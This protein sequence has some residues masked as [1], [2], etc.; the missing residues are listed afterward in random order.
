MKKIS[1]VAILF[2]FA[3]FGFAQDSIR[4]DS[5][6][7]IQTKGQH[8]LAAFAN[9]F[10]CLDC[11]SNRVQDNPIFHLAIFTG[12]NHKLVMN[13]NFSLETGLFLE[14]RSHSGGNNTLSNIVVFPKIILQVNDTIKI[15]GQKFGVF[16]RGGDF[17]DEDIGDFLRHYNIDYQAIIAE[18][19]FNKWALSFMTIGDLSVNIGLNL[20]QT[21]RGAIGYRTSQ[22]SNLSS[23]TF[24]ELTTGPGSLHPTEG[25][26]NLSNYTK[27]IISKNL[28]LEGQADARINSEIGS[29]FAFGLKG[30]YKRKKFRLSSSLR[31]YSG[32]YNLGYNGT[33]PNYQGLGETYVG[34]QLY[35]LKNYYR[36]Y[37]QWAA[38]THI[39]PSDLLAFVFTS[40]WD[41]KLYKK[42]GIFYDLDFNYIYDLSKN[43]DYVFPIYNFGIQVDFLSNFIGKLSLT[44]KHMEL[45]NYYQTFAVSEKPFIS[46]GVSMLIKPLKPKTS[47]IQ[48]N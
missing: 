18:L 42:S 27:K 40:N 41:T 6:F 10:S 7:T 26:F 38:Y 35:P 22:I 23:I 31:Y 46:L 43:K 5:E 29:S 32:D 9:D 48:R 1:L 2:S 12:I 25:D 47:Y 13:D 36:N 37:S 28:S 30:N 3:Y 39:G 33:Q 15:K 45:R 11:I 20:P 24:N 19:R 21:Y 17:W 4:M 8:N 34:R 16:I 44:N 14:E